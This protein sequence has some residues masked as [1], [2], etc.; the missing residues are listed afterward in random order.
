[1]TDRLRHIRENFAREVASAAGVRDPRIEA[2]FSATPREEFAGPGPWLIA[3]G[4][5]YVETPDDDPARL[6][7]NELVAIDAARGINIGEPVL[8]AMCLDALRVQDGETVV[9]V[10]AGVGYYTA[11]LARL[12]GATGRVFAY[13]IDPAIA[14]RA[15]KNLEGFGNVDVRAR[16][17]VAPDLPK[18]DAV[19]VNASAV[20]PCREWRDALKVGG[21]LMFPLEAPG[22]LGAMLL[23]TRPAGAGAWPARMMLTV[24][25]IACESDRDREATRRLAEAFDRGGWSEVRSL[26]FDPPDESTWLAGD[27]WRLS[28]KA[29]DEP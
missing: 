24:A 1:M 25:F 22:R 19:Y 17:G 11:I 3:E 9:H 20:A 8:H 27:G 21:R 2:A 10:G 4:A 15:A 23:L 5:G 26:R 7:R 14:A 13:E 29:P 16:S 28:S 18:A 12:V 6:Y